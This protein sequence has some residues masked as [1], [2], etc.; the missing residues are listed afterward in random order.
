MMI[1]NHHEELHQ[2]FMEMIHHRVRFHDDNYHRDKIQKLMKVTVENGQDLSML[3]HVHDLHHHRV[4]IPRQMK[5]VSRG[6]H[7]NLLMTMSEQ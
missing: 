6:D 7:Q 1:V 2:L 5:I 4:I 3:I